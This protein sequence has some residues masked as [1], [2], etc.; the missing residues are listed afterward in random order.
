MPKIH[1]VLQQMIEELSLQSKLP[2]A[3]AS[4]V[5]KLYLQTRGAG[6]EL[7]RHL[8]TLCAG[9]DWLSRGDFSISTEHLH[10]ADE[11]FLEYFTEHPAASILNAAEHGG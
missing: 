9:K 1:D 4:E 10:E 5:L 2:P 8:E 11:L 7:L 6:N 3:Q